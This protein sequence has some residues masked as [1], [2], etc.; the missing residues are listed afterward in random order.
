[1]PKTAATLVLGAHDVVR[2]G[3]CVW[4]LDRGAVPRAVDRTLPERSK[5]PRG[6]VRALGAMCVVGVLFAEDAP[7][8]GRRDD[9]C[10][11]GLLFWVL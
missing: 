3:P 11:W 1:M 10:A 2:P 6:G 4:V 8:A 7:G 9:R 5:G